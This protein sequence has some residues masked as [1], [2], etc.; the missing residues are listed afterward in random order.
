[1]E[2]DA[3]YECLRPVFQDMVDQ[4][5]KG[6][7]LKQHGSDVKFEDQHTWKYMQLCGP[8][9]PLF[10]M[11]KKATEAMER[12][13]GEA[14]YQELIGALNYGVFAAMILKKGLDP[15]NRLVEEGAFEGINT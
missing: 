6:K 10:Q 5:Q 2:I 4:I 15:V 3:R 9:G 8:G 12:M 14:Q 13:E 11:F 1:M 7:G